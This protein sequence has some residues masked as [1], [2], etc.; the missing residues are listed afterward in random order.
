MKQPKEWEPR[1]NA[2]I[3]KAEAAPLTEAAVYCYAQALHHIPEPI[4]ES[5]YAT[6]IYTALGE[7]HFLRGDDEKAFQS[8]HSAIR[9]QGGLGLSHIHLRLGQL[10]LARGET[11]RARDELMRA[12][13]GSGLKIFDGEDPKYY[14]LIKDIVEVGSRSD[15]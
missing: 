10:R 8:F 5:T 3:K 4:E 7:I 14:A 11:E 15:T 13:M 12:Y 6:Q 9:C 1:V 2:L